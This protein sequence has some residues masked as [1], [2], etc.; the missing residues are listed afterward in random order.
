MNGLFEH[1]THLH[2]FWPFK[3]SSEAALQTAEHVS[4]W[5][6]LARAQRSFARALRG[7]DALN[8]QFENLTRLYEFWP[9]K[10]SSS[11]W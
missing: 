10:T 7:R 6:R 1:L 4:L 2:E 9:F 8:G 5:L 3:T 11:P